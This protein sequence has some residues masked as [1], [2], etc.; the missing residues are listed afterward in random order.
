MIRVPWYPRS[1]PPRR[2]S[3]LRPTQNALNPPAV[4]VVGSPRSGTTYLG[5]V[6][7]GFAGY[8]DAGELLSPDIPA[9]LEMG[10]AE[11]ARAM[12]EALARNGFDLEPGSPRPVVHSPEMVFLVPALQEMD[13]STAVIHLV[14]DGRD[15]VASLL[16]LGWLAVE[17]PSPWDGSRSDEW[18]WGNAS[19]FWTEPNRMAEFAVVPEAR[20]AAWAWRRHVTSGLRHVGDG[21]GMATIRYETMCRRPRRCAARLA[22][23]VGVD[24][25][26]MHEALSGVSPA[27][28]GQWRQRLS[29][30]DL[31]EIYREAGELLR[32]LGCDSL[33]PIFDPE[34]AEATRRHPRLRLRTRLG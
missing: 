22:R 16:S 34:L 32:L 24:E 25:D 2:R 15:V 29:P 33:P 17:P 4:F 7:G 28:V 5:G 6:L 8:V 21:G 3:H 14:R 18:K 23:L 1:I 30:D 27:A 9:L 20:R 12:K 19:R 26:A 13:P 11:A 31:Q 10:T